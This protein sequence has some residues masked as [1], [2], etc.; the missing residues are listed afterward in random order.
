MLLLS[1]C[2]VLSLPSCRRQSEDVQDPDS[3]TASAWME[4]R[5]GE[6]KRAIGIF[7][8]ISEN[9]KVSK[10]VRTHALYGLACAHWHKLPDLK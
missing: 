8:D 3:R 10:N 2:I 7:G 5:M 4:F 9:S 6:D 1:L